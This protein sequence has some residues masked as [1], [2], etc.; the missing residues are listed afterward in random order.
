MPA[1][2]HHIST[3]VPGHTYRQSDIR[4]RIKSWTRDLRTRRLIHNVYNR[5]GIETRA[6]VLGDFEPDGASGPALYQT[7]S[8]ADGTTVLPTGTAARNACYSR[9][10]RTL[11][12]QVAR[13]ALNGAEGFSVADVTHIIFASCT[14]FT[15]PGPDYHIIRE[16][17]LNPGVERYTLGFMGCY[18]AFPAL[19]MAGQ[20][21]EA[22]PRAVVLVVCLELC[23]LH[24][25]INDQPDSILAN[26]LF[27]DGAAA[28]V[29]SSRKPPPEIPAYRLQSFASALVTD[30]EADMAWD[31]GNE[32]FNIV[33]SSYVPEILGARVRA[34]MEGILQRN[35]LKIEEIDSWAVHP[36]GRAILDK[37]EEALHLPATAL[38]ASRQILRDFGNMSSATVLFVL[39][40]L[41][42]SADTPAALT[43]AMAF[44]PGLTVETA[45]LERCGCTLPVNRAATPA[46]GETA[47]ATP[48]PVAVIAVA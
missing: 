26:S 33:L 3:Q 23:S 27:A 37:V 12:V 19:R 39:K 38:R 20:F 32:G 48:A 9:E 30:G 2:I 15:N 42:D 41:L 43:C 21:C 22:N 36:G 14:G 45:V 35:G 29:V 1:Y 6:S 25:Q 13:Q 16:L 47:E 7:A 46:T 4:D 18:A 34:L 10:A 8:S 40:E 17:G 31:I 28:V 24:L 44:G 11:A 5:S